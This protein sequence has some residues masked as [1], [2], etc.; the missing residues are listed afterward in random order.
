MK[1]QLKFDG[2]NVKTFS[3]KTYLTIVHYQELQQHIYFISFF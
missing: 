2:Y 3:S 1:H